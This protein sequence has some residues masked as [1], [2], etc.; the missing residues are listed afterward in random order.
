MQDLKINIVQSDIV[1]E[2]IAANHRKFRDL[3]RSYEN[4]QDLILL[5]EMFSTGFSMNCESLAEEP[6]GPTFLWM[7]QMAKSLNSA[8]AGTYVVR[9]HHHF[10]NRLLC[11]Y[12]DGTYK[13]YDKKHLFRFGNEHLAYTAGNLPLIADIKGWK[14]KFMICYDLRFPVWARNKYENNSYEYDGLIYLAN[15]PERRIHHWRALLMARA[16]E[17]LSYAVG[18]NRI[19]DDGVGIRYSGSSM[20]CTATGEFVLQTEDN[21]AQCNIITLSRQALDDF[22]KH[23]NV[24]QDWDEFRLVDK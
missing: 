7:Q 3:L 14:L 17:N 11:M 24:G 16:I 1:W 5:P 15:W 2:D 20:A 12:P 19:G 4:A 8:I 21:K 13:T 6:G 18:V 23:F 22:R 10:Y 9:E